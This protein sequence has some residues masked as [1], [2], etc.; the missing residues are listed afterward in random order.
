METL[1]TIRNNI[2]IAAT[3]EIDWSPHAGPFWLVLLIVSMVAGMVAAAYTE[4]N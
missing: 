2:A 1:D 4:V 3:W